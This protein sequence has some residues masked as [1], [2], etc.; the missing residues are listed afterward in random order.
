M[1]IGIAVVGLGMAHKPHIQ[2]LRE[3]SDRARIVACY[4]P[5]AARRESFG[6][7]H[8]DL[9]VT[10]DLDAVLADRNVDAVVLPPPP[11][12]HRDLVLQCAAAKKHVLLEKPL[13]YP[14]ERGRQAVD[15]MARAD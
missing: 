7:L 15:A 1:T 6:K 12:A 10:G 3:L 8:P 14:T 2:G 5:T 11:M 9:P 4:S 13:D